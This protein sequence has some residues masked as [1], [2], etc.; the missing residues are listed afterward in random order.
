MGNRFYDETQIIVTQMP[1]P[2]V[3][4]N[5]KEGVAMKQSR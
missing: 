3:N 5:G 1:S 2:P 4:S